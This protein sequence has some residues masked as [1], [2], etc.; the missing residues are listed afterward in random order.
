MLASYQRRTTAGDSSNKALSIQCCSRPNT[1]WHRVKV[2]HCADHHVTD[3][4]SNSVPLGC[5]EKRVAMLTGL[6]RQE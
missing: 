2:H 1:K 3:G 5:S 4:H 6:L